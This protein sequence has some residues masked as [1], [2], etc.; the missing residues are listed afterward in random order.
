MRTVVLLLAAAMLA[1]CAE[2]MGSFGLFGPQTIYIRADGRASTDPVL[3]QQLETDRTSCSDA[4]DEVQQCMLEKGYVL[5]R[6]EEAATKLAE[7]AAIAEEK[8]RQ[9]LALAAEEAKKRE[10]LAAALKKKT[11]KKKKQTAS[12]RN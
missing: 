4:A 11:K 12:P 7:F 2:K 8:K 10:A 5:V 3:A 1:S 6:T 9:Q